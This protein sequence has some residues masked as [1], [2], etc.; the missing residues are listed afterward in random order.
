MTTDEVQG[1]IQDGAVQ[2]AGAGWLALVMFV[3]AHWFN[4]KLSGNNWSPWVVMP[5]GIIGSL[6]LYV[7]TWSAAIS[8]WVL[9]IIGATIMGIICLGALVGT[10]ADLWVDPTYNTVAVWCL[11]IAPVMAHG[12]AGGFGGFI[13]NAY[14]SLAL[15]ALGLVIGLFG[16]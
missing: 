13:D 15:T 2:Y 3:L 16:G 1:L 10:I 8:G 12:S 9:G 11:I 7:S 5:T 14:S 4:Y 6:V